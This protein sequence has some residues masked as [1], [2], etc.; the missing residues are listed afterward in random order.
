[1]KSKF[2]SAILS[3]SAL[4]ACL[5][6][7]PLYAAELEQAEIKTLQAQLLKMQAQLDAVTAALGRGEDL[8]G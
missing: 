8:T 3:A 6:S 7:T 5:F 1:M 4:G 2:R